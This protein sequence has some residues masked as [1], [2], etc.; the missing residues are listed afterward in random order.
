M[1]IIHL[2]IR[3][4]YD[5]WTFYFIFLIFPQGK[6]IPSSDKMQAVCCC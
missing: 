5:A 4:A 3:Y 6:Q 2:Y 1:F